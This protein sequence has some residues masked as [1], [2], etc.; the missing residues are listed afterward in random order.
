MA[1]GGFINAMLGSS[2]ERIVSI[3]FLAALGFFILLMFIPTIYKVIKK[4]R[5]GTMATE[6]V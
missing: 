6:S 2:L 1:P 3:Q 5:S 4:K